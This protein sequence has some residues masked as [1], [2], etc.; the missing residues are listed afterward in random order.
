MPPLVTSW[1]RLEWVRICNT[2]FWMNFAER[3]IRPTLFLGG[4]SVFLTSAGLNPTLTIFA[5]AYRTADH[6]IIRLWREGAF[7]TDA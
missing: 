7:E 4:S 6:I 5:L 1:A 3:T 2:A